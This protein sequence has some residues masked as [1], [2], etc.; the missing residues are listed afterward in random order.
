MSLWA[1]QGV[2]MARPMPAARLIEAL[3]TEWRQA[4]I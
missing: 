1:G 2:A 4:S 3:V